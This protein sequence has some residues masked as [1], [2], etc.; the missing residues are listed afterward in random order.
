M[1]R[2]IAMIV[3]AAG[4]LAGCGRGAQTVETART[5]PVAQ[6]VE[7]DAHGLPARWADEN[8]TRFYAAHLWRSVAVWRY[9]TALRFATAYDEARRKPA[10]A[11]ASTPRATSPPRV[12]GSVDA[13]LWS[14]AACESHTDP[15]AVSS[16]GKFR[17]AWQFSLPT[18]H[19]NGGVG[20]PID[21]PL[22]TQLVVARSVYATQGPGAWPVCQHR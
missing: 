18:Y 20:D 19:A 15:T 6:D 12:S 10:A 1:L 14:I 5:V 17:G 4:V 16:S 22:D 11:P 8:R 3:L 7:I 9:A 21:A 2:T 13:H